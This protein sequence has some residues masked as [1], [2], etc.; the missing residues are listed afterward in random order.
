MTGLPMMALHFL[1]RPMVKGPLIAAAVML[2]VWRLLTA[3]G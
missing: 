1:A 3:D 2:V